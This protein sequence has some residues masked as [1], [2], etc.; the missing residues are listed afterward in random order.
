L[1]A[2]KFKATFFEGKNRPVNRRKKI[3]NLVKGMA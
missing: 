2:N 1:G 3:Y